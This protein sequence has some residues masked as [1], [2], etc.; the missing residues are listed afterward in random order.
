MGIIVHSIQSIV[1]IIVTLVAILD[2][3]D[4]KRANPCRAEARSMTER[5]EHGLL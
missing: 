5:S 1:A 2:W 3:P 4:G